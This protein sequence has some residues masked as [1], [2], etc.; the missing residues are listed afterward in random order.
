MAARVEEKRAARQ[1][2]SGARGRRGSAGDASAEDSLDFEES[3]SMPNVDAAAASAAAHSRFTR[4]NRGLSP[5]GSR[6]PPPTRSAGLYANLKA[7]STAD[8]SISD[9]SLDLSESAGAPYIS[10]TRQVGSKAMPSVLEDSPVERTNAHRAAA[11]QAK[12]AGGA[13]WGQ[14]GTPRTHTLEVNS[15]RVGSPG[16][17]SDGS[18]LSSGS[19]SVPSPR[20]TKRSPIRNAA[21]E[22][23]GVPARSARDTY[24]DP[25]LG[26]DGE[27][28]APSFVPRLAGQHQAVGSAN[29]TQ[30]KQAA[31]QLTETGGGS[32]VVGG[33]DD[34]GPGYFENNKD[35]F[36]VPIIVSPLQSDA[37]PFTT[38]RP[39]ALHTAETY[40]RGTSEAL[41]D[42]GRSPRAAT[43]A[44]P[45]SPSVASAFTQGGVSS[46][47]SEAEGIPSAS[48]P[49]HGLQ[50]DSA[51]QRSDSPHTCDVPD[52][53]SGYSS[54]GFERVG[55][56][57][58]A[59]S[60]PPSAETG[61]ASPAV[62]AA[63]SPA[64]ATKDGDSRQSAIDQ[65]SP[66]VMAAPRAA[67][68]D[69]A[70]A[71]AG[72][73]SS[74][75]SSA[76]GSNVAPSEPT[77]PFRSNPP[78]PPSAAPSQP[79]PAREM[80]S[81]MDI[82]ADALVASLQAASIPGVTLAGVQAALAA[83][84]ADT[85]YAGG[86]MATLNR[87]AYRD[88][89]YEETHGGPSV[90]RGGGQTRAAPPSLPAASY[91]ALPPAGHLRSG[92]SGQ[93]ASAAGQAAARRARREAAR[94]SVDSALPPAPPALDR[95][96][97]QQAARQQQV[98]RW[99][100]ASSISRTSSVRLSQPP[101]RFGSS[102]SKTN[103]GSAGS[104][105]QLQAQLQEQAAQLERG[106]A[107][108]D[109]LHWALEREV[110]Q[111][112]ELEQQLQQRNEAASMAARSGAPGQSVADSVAHWTHMNE[113][114]QRLVAAVVAS[115]QRAVPSGSG[116]T[117]QH[118]QRLED[119]PLPGQPV[120]EKDGATGRFLLEASNTAPQPAEGT[121]VG[122]L[123][124]EVGRLL[125]Q[126]VNEQEHLLAGFQAENERLVAGEQSVRART[127]A[128]LGRISAER[129]ALAARVHALSGILG[130]PEDAPLQ[131]LAAQAKPRGVPSDAAA[132]VP[133]PKGTEDSSLPAPPPNLRRS[134]EVHGALRRELAVAKT[135][136]E[137]RD[138]RV[139]DY[140]K[141]VAHIE[142]L[143]AELELERGRNSA[144]EVEAKKLAAGAASEDSRAMTKLQAHLERAKAEHKEELQHLGR[145]L[146]WYRDNQELLDADAMRLREQ[147]G[148]IDTLR[149][150]GDDLRSQLKRAKEAALPGS[151]T[152]GATARRIQDLQ[153]ALAAAEEALAKRHPDS[154]ASIVRAATS[155]PRGSVATAMRTAAGEA[156]AAR[157]AANAEAEDASRRVKAVRQ[158]YER[159]VAGHQR[160]CERLEQALRHVAAKLPP[161]PGS[162]RGGRAPLDVEQL[163]ADAMA[164]GGLP[165]PQGK[166]PGAAS[167]QSNVPSNDTV[168]SHA[169]AAKLQEQL[170]A[171]QAQV[172]QLRSKLAASKSDLDTARAFYTKKLKTQAEEAEAALKAAKRAGGGGAR[173]VRRSGSTG[174]RGAGGG[175]AGSSVQSR[176]ASRSGA[177]E[178]SS[179][180]SAPP[181]PKAARLGGSPSRGGG[182]GRQTDAYSEEGSSAHEQELQQQLAAQ[183]A[184]VASLRVQLVRAT[185]AA[186]DAV[187]PS[188]TVIES[189]EKRLK[190]AEAEA[191]EHAGKAIQVERL[192]GELRM[193][194]R[195][196][197]R[198]AEAAAKPRSA[199]VEQLESLA[200]EVAHLQR[201][202]AEREAELSSAGAAVRVRAEAEVARVKMQAEQQ[203]QA[204]HDEVQA[205]RSELDALLQALQNAG[206]SAMAAA[207]A[208]AVQ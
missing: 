131:T 71:M 81:A 43:G 100:Q 67:A 46:P 18:G 168:D 3:L 94:S 184:Q 44:A 39:Q 133:A 42:V 130:V 96:L 179:G 128:E 36:T 163:I 107:Q 145:K 175:G 208:L 144:L 70:A 69:E 90:T 155:G 147:S 140:H 52:A 103:G 146:Q 122:W 75:G 5:G 180:A 106:Q 139:A 156:A 29:Y 27:D 76:T 182:A 48:S 15:G 34:S 64:S 4:S 16:G 142:K 49:Q 195:Q 192:K 109:E 181:R 115:G 86:S 201:R 12:S 37:P 24:S 13:F 80:H 118:V 51:T 160:R 101:R 166:T 33:L 119:I 149:R 126:Q 137:E 177:R 85:L 157:A 17:I 88:R 141:F 47:Q 55:G 6:S 58:Q 183:E 54:D 134:V 102:D 132:L 111:R 161:P 72:S 56:R 113:R 205:M 194:S 45:P 11:Q 170:G 124:L 99:S 92:G 31:T 173:G 35:F 78:S 91:R 1:A 138:L 66:P 154:V 7:P 73:G 176:L 32:T 23:A 83:R 84:G 171:A 199:T 82:A 110:E 188:R 108:L 197:K 120:P 53:D 19:G 152:S 178:G 153:R 62:P 89:Y 97:P 2:A 150:E 87:Q 59:P 193:L 200:G 135:L 26:L 159:L 79:P 77:G 60:P 57:T 14:P 164:A 136:Q 203:L 41:D 151:S 25:S 68:A 125:L 8:I 191:A 95:A 74:H 185:E 112:H 143:Q 190:A 104:A 22:A 40:E 123:P 167:A 63:S 186:A 114:F 158:E 198:L 202:N 117:L 38:H 162:T 30:E 196:N 189:L 50:N 165:V 20:T 105:K 206:G 169:S 204:K 65:G 116:P 98:M 148:T 187:A 172:K 28:T 9:S 129:D 174:K 127:Q 93:P 207:N 121:A 10:S 21:K 61:D